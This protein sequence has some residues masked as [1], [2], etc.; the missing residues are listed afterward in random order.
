MVESMLSLLGTEEIFEL[1]DNV[2]IALQH[3]D[4]ITPEREHQIFG[5]DFKFD[6]FD[7]ILSCVA[8][9]FRVR[10]FDG[11]ERVGPRGT[12]NIVYNVSNDRVWVLTKDVVERVFCSEYDCSQISKAGQAA[13]NVHCYI[14][15]EPGGLHVRRTKK[16]ANLSL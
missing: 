13:E 11:R 16:K 6:K 15:I 4:F 10:V 8:H 12:C 2:C 3:G 7:S 9:V 14:G 1:I 5:C